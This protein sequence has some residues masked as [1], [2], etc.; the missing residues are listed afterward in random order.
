MGEAMTVHFEESAMPIQAMVKQINTIQEVMRGV[1][2][3]DQHYG[4]IPGTDKPSLLKPGAEKLGLTFRLAP[5]YIVETLTGE[6]GH[7]EYRVKC[8]LTHIPTG[9]VV[10]AGLGICSTMETKYRYISDVEFTGKPVPK[11]YWKNR[12]ASLLGPKGS[13]AKKNPQTNQWEIAAIRGKVDREDIADTYNTC[14]KMAKKRA[15]VDAILTATAASDIFTQDLEEEEDASRGH[16]EK[17]SPESGELLQEA[18]KLRD[19]M[20]TKG[21]EK[22]AILGLLSLRVKRELKKITDMTLEEIQAA[23]QDMEGE[24]ADAQ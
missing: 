21:H 6:H 11:E 17:P 18:T 14:I 16:Q 15:H 24:N 8:T 19:L 4:V 9:A 2:K 10:G 22:K 7:R 3:E 12:D 20:L 13:V 5:D 1:M 23:I